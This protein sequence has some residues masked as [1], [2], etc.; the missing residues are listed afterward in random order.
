MAT[1]NHCAPGY[2]APRGFYNACTV[3]KA[4]A[5]Y[6]CRYIFNTKECL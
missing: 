2:T 6:S 5:D 4:S 1:L 3:Q